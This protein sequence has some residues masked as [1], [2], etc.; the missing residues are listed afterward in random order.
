MSMPGRLAGELDQFVGQESAGMIRRGEGASETTLTDA[1]ECRARMYAQRAASAIKEGAPDTT[2]ITCR[3]N[4]YGEELFS[5][6]M[7]GKMPREELIAFV[8]EDTAQKLLSGDIY[9]LLQ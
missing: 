6:P 5:L 2:R 7:P 1:K 9:S 3:T 4:R 8:G